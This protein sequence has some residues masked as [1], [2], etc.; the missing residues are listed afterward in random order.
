MEKR[1]WSKAEKLEVLKEAD[2]KGVEVT[3]RKYG[4]YP[5]TLYDWPEKV[6]AGRE[7][8]LD[9]KKHT[10]NNGEYLVQLE[11]ENSRLKR[12]VAE[13]ALEIDLYKELGKKKH[14]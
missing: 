5:A 10:P 1:K 7:S 2:E 12:L 11:S 13:M 6:K 3:L 8:G 9:R 4:I 14:P